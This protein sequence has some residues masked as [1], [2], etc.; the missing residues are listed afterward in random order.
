M[1]LNEMKVNELIDRAYYASLRERWDEGELDHLP[2]DEV[3][4]WELLGIADMTVA[5]HLC[6]ADDQS[7]VKEAL[8]ELCKEIKS[9]LNAFKDNPSSSH[10]YYVS[11]SSLEYV[12]KGH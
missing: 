2:Y 11:R 8:D 5:A 12:K 1:N 10:P 3:V 6:E 9:K 7:K 4:L